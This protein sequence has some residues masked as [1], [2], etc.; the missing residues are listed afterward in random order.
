LRKPE[1]KDINFKAKIVEKGENKK[2]KYVILNQTG[3]YPDG[4]GGQLGDRGTIDNSKVLKIEE[5]KGKIFH[6]VDQFPISKREVN[7]IIFGERRKDI[8]IHHT[9]QHILS[10]TF[11]KLFNIETTSFHMGEKYCTIDLSTPD[12]SQEKIEK[13][14][15][16]ANK[17]VMKN[18]PVK[19]YFV[20]GEELERLHL[21]K[22]HSVR[23]KIRI[24]EIPNFDISMCGGTHVNSTGEIGTIKILKYEK[25]K[26][27]F[28][29]IY[30]IAG[31]RALKDYQEKEKTLASLSQILT[32]GEKELKEKI[33][34]MLWEIKS[35]KKENKK[36]KNEL[37][38]KETD[39]LLTKATE[40]GSIKFVEEE[41][42]NYSKEE[43]I[44][45]ALRLTR[46]GNIFTVLNRKD[47][48]MDVV[49]SRGKNIPID[50]IK[51]R[52]GILKN[53][54]VKGG[55]SDKFLTLEF[56][57]KKEFEK[58]KKLIKEKIREHQ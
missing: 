8:S 38:K 11:I 34:L 33:K 13:A 36:L 40:V 27:A 32:T 1:L 16:L 58:L 4:K 46:V 28:H 31:M 42:N 14:E 29:R 52:E 25:I 15:E 19:K 9:A 22:K 24:I 3:F 23:G 18:M 49:I 56:Q 10:G 26:K 45:I 44:S 12:I 35:L 17:I 6:F 53:F 57:D 41:I 5:K 55:G 20:T 50:L 2:E 39:T 37:I 48:T 47:K 30:F 7:C 21:R 51:L 54:S 43:L